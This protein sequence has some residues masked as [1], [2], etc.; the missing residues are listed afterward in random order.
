[1]SPERKAYRDYLGSASGQGVALDTPA[2]TGEQDW[3]CLEGQV[4]DAHGNC[5][6]E[7]DIGKGEKPCPDC[8]LREVTPYEDSAIPISCVEYWCFNSMG[9][10][11]KRASRHF[12][13]SAILPT[14]PKP[15]ATV[16]E[17]KK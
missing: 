2:A 17:V 12:K 9:E 14:E 7:D 13:Q 5:I 1:M 4:V 8:T 3:E 16:A 10:K 6:D 15:I 11:L